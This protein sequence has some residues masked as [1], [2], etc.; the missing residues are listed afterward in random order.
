MQR[1][2]KHGFRVDDEMAKETR[3]IVTGGHDPRAEEWKSAEPS[4]EDQ[5]AVD[6]SADGSMRGG[7]PD[8]L[9]PDDL[10][11]RAELAG[12]LGKEL[13]PAEGARVKALLVENQA[14][15]RLIALC[16]DLPDGRVYDNVAE[17]WVDLTGHK[18]AHRF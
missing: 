8:G 15:D 9:T 13:W 6:L 10:E 12:F 4:G 14:P 2:D 5:P 17:V 16:A 1:G 18:E 7:V 11:G 3:A